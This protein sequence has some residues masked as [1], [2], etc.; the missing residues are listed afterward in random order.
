[1]STCPKCR[2][3]LVPFTYGDKD[4]LKC[5]KCQGFWFRDGLFRDVKQIGFAGLYDEEMLEI[6]SDSYPS[7][8]D[9]ELSCPDCSCA[10]LDYNY[11]YSSDIQLHRCTECNGIWADGTDLRAIDQLLFNY[12][13]SLEEAKAKAMPLMMEVKRQFEEKERV[14]EDERKQMRK[15]GL[16]EKLFR[17]RES[18]NRKIEN[19]FDDIHKSNKNDQD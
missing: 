10:L 4:L 7:S 13:E 19:I 6:P 16:F 9:Q 1:M 11:A 2:A 12:K 18:R 15:R 3:E 14:W 5:A 8:E 17:K